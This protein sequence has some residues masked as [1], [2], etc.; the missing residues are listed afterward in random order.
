MP[1][2]LLTE[3]EANELLTPLM[4]DF[5]EA[6]LE[7][8]EAWASNPARP[9]AS[10]RSRASM[11]HDEITNR[12]EQSFDGHARVRVKRRDNSLQ[13][14][15]DGVA[16]IK[17]KKLRRRGL[18]TDG[19]LTNA[20]VSFLAQRGEL[21]GRPVTNLVL[22]YRLDELELGVEQIYLTCPL[23]RRNLWALRLTD[24]PVAS[25][26]LLDTADPDEERTIIRSLRVPTLS[27]KIAEEE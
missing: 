18:G 22:G 3:S 13:M 5:R 8:W 24:K 25:V 4:D 20:R 17:V 10:K 9:T 1:H 27:T 19:I 7:G 14:S 6:V 2:G 16:I 21:C 26:S 12:L 23:G 15:V 11:I